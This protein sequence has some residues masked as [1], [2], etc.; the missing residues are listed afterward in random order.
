M[1]TGADGTVKPL[2]K[3][4]GLWV[5][6]IPWGVITYWEGRCNTTHTHTHTHTHTPF[7]KLSF[8]Y[9]LRQ[10]GL[11][12]MMLPKVEF[13]IFLLPAWCWDYQSASPWFMWGWGWNSGPWACCA[14]TLPNGLHLDFLKN[15]YF[16]FKILCL[17][18][19]V[20]V[21]MYV[22]V[23]CMSKGSNSQNKRCAGGNQ[24]DGSVVKHICC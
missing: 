22:N 16:I 19:C 15:I 3:H 6:S 14:G 11:A 23:L 5:G 24:Q 12:L 13:L 4:L 21:S 9:L 17:W 2:Q 7:S 8:R 10:M 20:S 1:E 18:V